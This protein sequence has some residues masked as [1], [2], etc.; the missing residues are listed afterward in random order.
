M[1]K[2]SFLVIIAASLLTT[3]C[4]YPPPGDGYDSPEYGESGPAVLPPMVILDADPF[5]YYNGYHYHYLNGRWFYSRSKN[6]PWNDLPRNRYPREVRFKEGHRDME[7]GHYKDHDGSQ[8]VR[9]GEGGRGGDH[10]R[11]R[12]GRGDHG[13]NR[14]HGGDRG[15]DRGGSRDGKGDHGGGSGGDRDSRDST[16]FHGRDRN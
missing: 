15:G 6:G 12:D 2:I 4:V 3:A 5:Y 11:N 1:K 9:P 13:W 16:D 8:N 14:D 7:R 10:G